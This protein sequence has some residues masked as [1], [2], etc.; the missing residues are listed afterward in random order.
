M[1]EPMGAPFGDTQPDR[2]PDWGWNRRPFLIAHRGY[3]SRAPE[4]TLASFEM[5]LRAGAEVLECDVQLTRD[6]A[7]A[8]MHDPD[9]DRTTD[10]KGPLQQKSWA[11][12]RALDAG[13]SDRFGDA[14]AGQRVPR[15]EEVLDLARHRAQVFI[16]IKPEALGS[17]PGGIELE[18]L[19]A[20]ER[21]RMMQDI[22]VLSFAPLAL[23]RVHSHAGSVPLGLV[24][25]WWRSRRLVAEA[26]AVE[27]D[28]IVVYAARLLRKPDIVQ[29]ARAHGLKV[30]AYVVDSNEH[31][32]P[33]LAWGVDGIATNCFGDLLPALEEREQ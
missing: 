17:G 19:R 18:T 14:F 1:N 26:L 8:V 24:F 21:T 23:Q 32:Q 25:R 11:Q 9:V 15:L 7:V 20:A 22:G 29:D 27:A 30:G 28:Y 4:N 6:G 31:L 5:A 13:Y 33:M 2:R 16:E 10:G 3:S 12:V